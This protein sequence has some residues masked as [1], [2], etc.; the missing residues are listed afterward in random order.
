MTLK[1][2]AR[3]ASSMRLDRGRFAREFLGQWLMQTGLMF[4]YLNC[5]EGENALNSLQYPPSKFGLFAPFLTAFDPS[6]RP[7]MKA[8]ATPVG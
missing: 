1:R 8:R 7:A 3:R 5:G 6:H 4:T 2:I